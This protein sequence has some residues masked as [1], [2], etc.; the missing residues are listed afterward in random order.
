MLHMEGH[1]YGHGRWYS[2]CVHFLDVAQNLIEN[3]ADVII[4]CAKVV[5]YCYSMLCCSIILSK[6]ADFESHGRL[7]LRCLSNDIIPVSLI[8]QITVITPKIF[9]I[10]K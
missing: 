8:L 5:Q 3:V 7:T 4:H 9:S 10:L 2:H 1:H 6:I